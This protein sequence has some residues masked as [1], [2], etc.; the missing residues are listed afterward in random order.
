MM[1]PE[2]ANMPLVMRSRDRSHPAKSKKSR[3]WLISPIRN[4]GGA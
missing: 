2:V 1:A 4:T 3:L